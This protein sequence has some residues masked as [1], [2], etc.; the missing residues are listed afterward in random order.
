ML[1]WSRRRAS[2]AVFQGRCIHAKMGTELGHS[3]LSLGQ[4]AREQLCVVA[5]ARR[6]L[7]GAFFIS[8]ALITCSDFIA[9]TP[10]RGG[11][12]RTSN[13][14]RSIGIRCW[15]EPAAARRISFRVTTKPPKTAK[16]TTRRRRISARCPGRSRRHASD[17]RRPRLVPDYVRPN[18]HSLG[19]AGFKIPQW[20]VVGWRVTPGRR[21]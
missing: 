18:L 12:G 20:E 16:R 3:A 10:S 8:F 5:R 4:N 13:F 1:D 19:I 6:G 11:R 21:I 15:N 7:S 2:R 17:R 14:F 9:S